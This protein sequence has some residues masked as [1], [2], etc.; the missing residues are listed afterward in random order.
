MSFVLIAAAVFFFMVRPV[1]AL[2]ARSRSEPPADPTTQKC[3]QCLRE[4]PLEAS[5]CAFC[6]QPVAAA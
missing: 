4:I 3:P 1:N 5:R 2:I 6:A